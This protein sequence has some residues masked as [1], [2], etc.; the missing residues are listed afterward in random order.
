LLSN[1]PEAEYLRVQEKSAREHDA[2]EAERL[3]EYEEERR[4]VEEVNAEAL[5][6]HEAE[7]TEFDALIQG[8]SA[9]RDALRAEGKLWKRLRAGSRIRRAKRRKPRAAAAW[10]EPQPPSPLTRS[11]TRREAQLEAGIE[12]ERGVASFLADSLGGDWTLV[13]GYRN[14]RG[15]IDQ[16]LLGPV[17]IIAIEVKNWNATVHVN[18]DQWLFEKYDNYGNQVQPLAPMRDGGGRPPSRELNE[19]ADALQEFLARRDQPTPI[20]RVVLLVHR[21]SCLGPLENLTVDVADYPGY[22]LELIDALEPALDPT[23]QARVEELI[24]GDHSFHEK[25]RRRR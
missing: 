10:A 1:H 13:R 14:A 11:P 8:L 2:Q 7:L 20:A 12:G 19:P 16:L 15:E 4:R 21:N 6:N 25:R 24:V 23:R 9:E 17:G 3:R 18:G 22:V 5:R